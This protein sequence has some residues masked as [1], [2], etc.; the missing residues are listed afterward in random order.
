MVTLPAVQ[1]CFDLFCYL[2]SA[3]SGQQRGA[4]H[5]T[6]GGPIP[7]PVS[8]CDVTADVLNCGAAIYLGQYVEMSREEI[9]ERRGGGEGRE[10]TS[11][12]CARMCLCHQAV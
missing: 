3:C 5:V 12:V 8:F 2:L 10:G 6:P 9:R 1:S 7:L 4:G 11:E